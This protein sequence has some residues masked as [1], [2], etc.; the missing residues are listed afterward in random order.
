MLWR[1]IDAKIKIK[2]LKKNWKKMDNVLSVQDKSN[3]H[4]RLASKF[5]LSAKKH[6]GALSVKTRAKSEVNEKS[7]LL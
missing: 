2:T 5:R 6:K 7:K 3:V 1:K 4:S